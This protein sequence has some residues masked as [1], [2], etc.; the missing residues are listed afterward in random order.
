MLLDGTDAHDQEDD[1]KN[2]EHDLE[3]EDLVEGCDAGSVDQRAVPGVNEHVRQEADNGKDASGGAE[4]S[5]RNAELGE[6]RGADGESAVGGEAEHDDQAASH[7]GQAGI[8]GHHDEGA[9]NHDGKREATDDGLGR[10][11]LRS[12]GGRLSS[13]RS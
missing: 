7:D 12:D 8:L 3:A 10:L 1:A 4:D 9:Q 11:S 5:H 2:S 6:R 13:D